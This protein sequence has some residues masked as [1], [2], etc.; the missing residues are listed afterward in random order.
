MPNTLFEAGGFVNIDI[1]SAFSNNA[2]S[3]TTTGVDEPAEAEATKTNGQLSD[4]DIR[5]K[6]KEKKFSDEIIEKLLAFGEPFKKVCRVLG[7]EISLEASG[8]RNPI[9]AFL[10]QENIQRNLIMTG[11]LNVNTFRALYNAVAKKLVADSEFFKANNY[12]IIYCNALYKKSARDIEAYLMLQK[13]ILNPTAG[14]YAAKDLVRN[15]VV[16]LQAHELPALSELTSKQRTA[17]IQNFLANRDS[18]VVLNE[19]SK[20]K[21]ETAPLNSLECAE[22]VNDNW[23]GNRTERLD[24]QGQNDIVSKLTNGQGNTSLSHVCATILYL[25]MNTNSKKAKAALN[26]E[27][28]K[29]L[30]SEQIFSAMTELASK[31]ILPKG[32]LQAE[33]A[34]ALID[35]LLAKL[36]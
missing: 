10:A 34:D 26:N 23:D 30:P 2:G 8:T 20:I 12:N 14:K 32:Q 7:F 3:T 5:A 9:L 19:L 36:P 25:A 16:F 18:N 27:K 28:F 29:K 4:E 1:R 35:K 22:D 31:S 17:K 21:I 6:L 24:D 11:L 15:K 33:E 13:D